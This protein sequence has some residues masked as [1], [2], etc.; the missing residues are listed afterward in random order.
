M[1][2][3]YINADECGSLPV[4][5]ALERDSDAH[6][7]PATR[8]ARL[9]SSGLGGETRDDSNTQLHMHVHTQACSPCP[10]TCAHK[11]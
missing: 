10:H 8:L 6:S 3:A 7:K 1:P 9:E 11:H 5:P 4:I 2:R